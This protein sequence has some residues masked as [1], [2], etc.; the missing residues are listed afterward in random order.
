MEII[1]HSLHK[2]DIETRSVSL[3]EYAE[4]DNVDN[5]V[6]DL[7]H[8]VS[9]NEGEREY[10][11]EEESITM[12]TYLGNIIRDNERDSTNESIARRLLQEE[13][14][15]QQKIE[16]LGAFQRFARLL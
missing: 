9:E 3:Q 14:K 16:H 11:F 10:L 5:Y 8:N 6:M 1:Y 15:A 4:S 2:I 13:I 7:L 12:K